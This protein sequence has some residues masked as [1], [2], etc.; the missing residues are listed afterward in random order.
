[1]LG[2]QRLCVAAAAMTCLNVSHDPAQAGEWKLA[3]PLGQKIY[4]TKVLIDFADRVREV[5]N[6]EINITVTSGGK[7]VPHAGTWD[8]VGTGKV[9]LGQFYMPY[10]SKAD[11]LFSL[12]GLP[13]L[14]KS[15]KDARRLWSASRPFVEQ[16]LAKRGLTVLFATP[17]PLQGIYASKP[18]LSAA[19]LAGLKMRTQNAAIERFANLAGANAVSVNKD[20]IPTKFKEGA[21][22]SMMTSPNIGTVSKAWRFLS[23][24]VNL[25]VG[26]PKMVLVMNSELMARIPEKHRL[27]ILSAAAVAQLEGWQA[28]ETAGDEATAELA[29]NGITVSAASSALR[30]KLAEIDRAMMDEW[31]ATIGERGSS[32]IK[33]YLVD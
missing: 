30:E 19:D 15:Y 28:A 9:E 24:Y 1:M 8:K 25:K 26:A 20:N 4:L 13:L 14:V 32:I 3:A 16:A 33:S 22:D 12:D 23:H 2:L 31:L 10:L 11:P 21:I 18:V 17:W 29:A 6:G 7:L 5:T 27:A